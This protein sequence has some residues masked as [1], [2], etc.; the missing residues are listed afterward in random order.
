MGI[1]QHL[2]QQ[3]RGVDTLVFGLNFIKTIATNGNLLFNQDRDVHAETGSC[4]RT[5]GIASSMMDNTP[6]SGLLRQSLTSRLSNERGGRNYINLTQG[7][8]HTCYTT[9]IAVPAALQNLP[10]VGEVVNGC[11]ASS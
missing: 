8:F 6:R 4:A 3:R 5:D 1:K 11:A 7:T 9:Q 2:K 10:N